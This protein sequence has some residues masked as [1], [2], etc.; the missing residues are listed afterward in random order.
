MFVVFLFSTHPPFIV[1]DITEE[2][3]SEGGSDPPSSVAGASGRIPSGS[4]QAYFWIDGTRQKENGFI[5]KLVKKICGII[6]VLL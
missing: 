4:S 1:T 6:S 2:K 3:V 5:S